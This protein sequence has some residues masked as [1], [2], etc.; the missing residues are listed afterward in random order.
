MKNS[1][2]RLIEEKRSLGKFR[3]P[4]VCQEP[5]GSGRG[6]TKQAKAGLQILQNN[7]K[8]RDF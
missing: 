7:R 1:R 8:P 3:N 4:S 5:K 2:L 6:K